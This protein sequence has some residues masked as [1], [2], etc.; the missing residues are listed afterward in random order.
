MG[1]TTVQQVV[2]PLLAPALTRFTSVEAL[3]WHMSY[4]INGSPPL[5][6]D[7]LPLPP[8]G[9]FADVVRAMPCL[10]EVEVRLCE[11][12]SSGGGQAGE[13]RARH[14][15]PQDGRAWLTDEALEALASQQDSQL[16]SFSLFGAAHV[17]A[18]GARA[19][20]RLPRLQRLCVVRCPLV[21]ARLQEEWREVCQGRV[22]VAMGD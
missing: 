13:G 19:L 3:Q 6:W 18:S 10:S 16:R 1:A 2:Y 12:S 5:P 20:L 21:P 9:T 11:V 22:V 4:T 8:G 7:R 17:T 14:E 15:A